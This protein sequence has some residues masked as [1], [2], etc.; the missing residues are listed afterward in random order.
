MSFFDEVET[1]VANT[2]F[3][4][5][6][7][8]HAPI[9]LQLQPIEE[10]LELEGQPAACKPAA[11]TTHGPKRGIK[12]PFGVLFNGDDLDTCGFNGTAQRTLARPAS[13]SM[14]CARVAPT[15]LQRPRATS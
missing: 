1:T 6:V 9:A 11:G 14:L 12:F 7:E 5:A 4:Q 2:R 10:L 8:E 3:L 15:F 13:H